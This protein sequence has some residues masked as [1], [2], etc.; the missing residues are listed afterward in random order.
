MAGIS[1]TDVREYLPNLH[2]NTESMTRDQLPT[3]GE[4]RDLIAPL[5]AEI[6]DLK[7]EVRELKSPPASPYMTLKEAKEYHRIKSDTTMRERLRA[8]GVKP[9]K[10][11]GGKLLY[12]REDVERIICK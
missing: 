10:K 1:F 2:P 4:I 6:Q 7:A 8:A 3:L 9:V 5:L 12:N 11:P